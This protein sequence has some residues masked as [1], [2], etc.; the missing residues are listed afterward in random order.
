MKTSETAVRE[1]HEES[2]GV[3]SL[4]LLRDAID[5]LHQLRDG[6]FV[7]FVGRMDWIAVDALGQVAV[8]RGAGPFGEIAEPGLMLTVSW[9]AKVT[10]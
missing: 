7:Y 1:R 6:G 2:R 4:V 3:L 5:P 10:W 8:P 9:R